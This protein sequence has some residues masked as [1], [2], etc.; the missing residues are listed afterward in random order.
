MSEIQI[1]DKPCGFDIWVLTMQDFASQQEPPHWG[2]FMQEA[3]SW[4]ESRSKPGHFQGYRGEMLALPWVDQLAAITNG[5]GMEPGEEWLDPW[6]RITEIADQMR[7]PPPP[8]SPPPPPPLPPIDPVPVAR[9]TEPDE[10]EPA[11]APP[12]PPPP[13][14]TTREQATQTDQVKSS[15]VGLRYVDPVSKRMWWFVPHMDTWF[16]DD[17]PGQWERFKDPSTEHCY[18]IE[19]T[20]GIQW[21]QSPC[22]WAVTA[23]ACED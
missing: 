4:A 21:N 3:R 12:P 7:P 8:P 1:L 15:M 2:A 6:S 19:I 17:E 23:F 20:E 13:P 9:G 22:F 5:D 16:W 18:W 14:P 10:M 11:A